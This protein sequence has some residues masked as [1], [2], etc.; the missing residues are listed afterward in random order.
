MAAVER[1]LTALSR[2]SALLGGLVLVGLI[3]MSV[4][5]ITGR[6]L[7]PLGLTPIPG[8]FELVEAG[9]AFAVFCFLPWCQLSGGHVTVDLLKPALGPRRDAALE[10]VFNTLMTLIAAFITWRA[11]A[12]M[13]DKLQYN[14]TTF[15]LQLP[16]WWGYAICLPLGLL[17]VAVSAFTVY[18]SA[19][20]ALAPEPH[21]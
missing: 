6:A 7:V 21:R 5:S 1:V 8:D 20:L 19:R 3:I 18:R 4:L 15:I 13:G 16:V 17:F 11:F 10:V 9:T 14:E 2:L 12:G